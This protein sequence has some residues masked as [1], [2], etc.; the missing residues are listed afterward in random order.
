[1]TTE[2]NV[3]PTTL[4]PVEIE[5]QYS[6][7]CED[8]PLPAYQTVN[9]VGMDLRA[10]VGEM[11]T[12]KPGERRRVPTG[13]RLAIPPGF[14]GQVRPRSGLAMNDGIILPNA[15][16]TID[17]DFRGEVEVILMNLSQ[18]PFTIRRGDRIAQLIICPVTR[19][20]WQLSERLSTTERG[21]GGFGH[22]GV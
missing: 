22:T 10:A 7:G 8:I 13:I 12:I 21:E 5:V 9:S 4:V 19:C 3:E 6:P 14:E 1:M 17:P 20:S 15:P 18:T 2:F 11:V 16:G